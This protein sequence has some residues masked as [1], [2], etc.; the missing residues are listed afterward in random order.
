MLKIPNKIRIFGHDWKIIK[1]KNLPGGSYKWANKTIIIGYADGEEDK[2][3]FHEIL[4]A[5]LTENLCRY[6]TNETSSDFQFIFNH[7]K[8]YNVVRQFVEI[9]KDNKMI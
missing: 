2:V 1:D 9:L 8:F 5:V 7:S 6:Y 4:E 3:F